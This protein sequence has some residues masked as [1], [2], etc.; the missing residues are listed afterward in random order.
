MRA[1]IWSLGI[2]C[3][4]LTAALYATNDTPTARPDSVPSEVKGEGKTEGERMVIMGDYNFVESLDA[5]AEEAD[6]VVMARPVGDVSYVPASMGDITPPFAN[7]YQDLAISETISGTAT[8]VIRVAT[9]GWNPDSPVQPGDLSPSSE[10]PPMM[11]AMPAGDAI[12]FLRKF[13]DGSAFEGTYGVVGQQAGW[14]P[15]DMASFSRS[16]PGSFRSGVA[17]I[18]ELSNQPMLG[19]VRRIQQRMDSRRSR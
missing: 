7:F 6:T 16:A 14:V 17:Q 5:L 15:V 18:P 3:A 4:L 1:T 19:L 12:F 9:L 11:G 8:G 10:L 2:G 13:P